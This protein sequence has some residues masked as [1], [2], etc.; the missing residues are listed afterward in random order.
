MVHWLEKA[1]YL[2]RVIVDGPCHFKTGMAARDSIRKHFFPISGEVVIGREAMKP[3]WAT[4]ATSW[5]T[6]YALRDFQ[7]TLSKFYFVQDF[8]P[9]FYAVGSEYCLAE[10]T[11]RFGF[12]GITAGPWLSEL[13]RTRYGMEA[14]AFSFAVDSMV[15]KPNPRLDAKKRVFFYARPVTARRGFELGLLALIEVVRRRPEIEVVLGGWDLD[16]YSLPANFVSIGTVSPERLS[17]SISQCDVALVLS[18][19]NASLL[20][21]EAMACGCAIVSNKGACVDWL[22]NDRMAL[23]VEPTVEALSD[24]VVALLDD[25]TRRQSLIEGATA[26]AFKTDWTTEARTVMKILE[27]HRVAASAKR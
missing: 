2:C 24:A 10:E 7:A 1:G 22:L 3:A 15:F 20:P 4:V 19:T 14:D 27:A 6:A 12:H 8:E 23:L 21:L 9:A 25:D 11:Y 5:T 18:L 16:G 26:F 17:A 13:L